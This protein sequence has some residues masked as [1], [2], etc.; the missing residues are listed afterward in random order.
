MRLF[1]AFYCHF[2][3]LHVVSSQETYFK[4]PRYSENVLSVSPMIMGFPFCL[5]TCASGF[6]STCFRAKLKIKQTKLDES[7]RALS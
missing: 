4:S 2:E 5:G 3:S 7:L 1:Q 6:L